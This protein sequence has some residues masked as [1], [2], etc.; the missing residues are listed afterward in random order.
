MQKLRQ[1]TT[2]RRS[3]GRKVASLRY[4]PNG[5]M[6]QLEAPYDKNF[7]ETM[8]KSIPTKKRMW[9]D[10]DK[11]WYVVKDQFDKLS[12]LLNEYFDET[13][14][15]DFPAHEVS[16]SSWAMLYLVENAPLEVVCAAYRALAVKYHPDK[17]GDVAVMQSINQAYKNILGEL[18]NG[19]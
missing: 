13:L 16:D 6:L 10:Q 4:L 1:Q 15:L 3:H 8:K 17:G 9:D 14:L 12:H 7:T 19:D 18:K 11:C 5:L 2:G